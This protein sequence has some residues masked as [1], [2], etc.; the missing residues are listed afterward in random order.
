MAM[1]VNIRISVR[2]GDEL[3]VHVFSEEDRA[4]FLCVRGREAV[5]AAFGHYGPVRP[6]TQEEIKC[7]SIRVPLFL[8]YC[9]GEAAKPQA[10][11]DF[12]L[13]DV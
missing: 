10:C 4:L 6:V 1:Y 5:V 2:P 12:N 7:A 3:A 13:S 8:R 9:L 11:E